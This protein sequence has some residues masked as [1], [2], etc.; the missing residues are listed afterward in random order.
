VKCVL[1]DEGGTL[2][3]FSSQVSGDGEDAEKTASEFSHSGDTC[4]CNF[5][6]ILGTSLVAQW[7]RL[8]FQCRGQVCSLVREPTGCN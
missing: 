8:S 4:F 7:L 2:P 5:N 3:R 1:Q 6:N